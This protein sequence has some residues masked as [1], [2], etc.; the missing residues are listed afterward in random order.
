VLT[1]N[2]HVSFYSSRSEPITISHPLVQFALHLGPLLSALN[3]HASQQC[4]QQLTYLL[5]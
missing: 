4:N 1:H 5:K 2:P 3:D